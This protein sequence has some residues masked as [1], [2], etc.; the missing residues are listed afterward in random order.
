MPTG[1]QTPAIPGSKDGMMERDDCV[2]RS[3]I[4]H[5]RSMTRVLYRDPV[6]LSASGQTYE[7]GAIEGHPMRC[8]TDPKST[9]DIA[10]TNVH[11]HAHIC[12]DEK[13]EETPDDLG[14]QL[15][16]TR[17][18]SSLASE[19]EYMKM[20]IDSWRETFPELN[21]FFDTTEK[22][23]KACQYNIS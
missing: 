4:A 12:R 5:T 19:E 10:S 15:K 13:Q 9:A 21:D 6:N 18:I 8:S 22:Y 7:R 3:A 1:S 14:T 2:R 17:D 16:P 11:E 20:Y 23:L